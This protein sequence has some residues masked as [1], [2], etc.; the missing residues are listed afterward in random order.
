MK[1][2]SSTTTESSGLYSVKS[3]LS[4]KVKEE[5]KDAKFYCEVNYFVPGE[6]RMTETERITITVYCESHILKYHI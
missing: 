3:E 2:E 1:I 6:T 4:L 5:D